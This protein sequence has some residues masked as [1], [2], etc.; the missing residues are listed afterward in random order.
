MQKVHKTRTYQVQKMT[1]EDKFQKKK[2][3]EWKGKN[4]KR[5]NNIEIKKCVKSIWHGNKEK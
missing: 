2:E 5:W 4:K 3:V 1:L